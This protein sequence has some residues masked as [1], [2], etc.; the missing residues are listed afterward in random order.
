MRLAASRRSLI[1]KTTTMIYRKRISQRTLCCTLA[2]AT[3]LVHAQE[4][5][6][7]A[8]ELE[9]VV[10]TG[11]AGVEDIRKVEVSY[12]VTTISGES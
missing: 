12:A 2:L 5:N 11:R 9:T 3:S 1:A 6:R 8:Q 4:E 7:G 10:V